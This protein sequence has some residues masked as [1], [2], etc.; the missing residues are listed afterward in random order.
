MKNQKSSKLEKIEYD[1]SKARRRPLTPR[2]ARCHRKMVLDEY[3]D[4]SDDSEDGEEEGDQDEDD[5][6]LL[7]DSGGDQN[8]TEEA[9]MFKNLSPRA[10][11]NSGG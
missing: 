1:A 8:S 6:Q 11:G 3:F 7:I 9:L 5:D 10:A 2:D 4:M